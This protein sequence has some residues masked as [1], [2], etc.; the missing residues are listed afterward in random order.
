MV[1]L[2][3]GGGAF[4]VSLGKH[5]TQ[6]GFYTDGS[7]SVKA[8]IIGDKVYGRDRTGHIVAIFKAPDGKNVND[9]AWSKQITDELD[10][11][12]TDHPNQVLGWAGYLKAPDTTSP[13]V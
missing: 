11:F 12:V 2:C 5:A 1:A 9:P 10:K 8:S 7:Q 13:I 3:L 4:G 6:S